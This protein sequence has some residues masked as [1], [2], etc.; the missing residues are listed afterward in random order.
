MIEHTE[1]G[2]EAKLALIERATTELLA[3][4]NGDKDPFVMMLPFDTALNFLIKDIC[5]MIKNKEL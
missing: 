1:L 4:I 5:L 2:D 3:V